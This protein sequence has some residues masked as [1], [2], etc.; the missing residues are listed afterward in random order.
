MAKHWYVTTTA[1]K[2][3]ALA[4]F[5]RI[6]FTR[7]QMKER[8]KLSKGAQLRSQQTWGQA[9]APN[10]DVAAVLERGGIREAISDS[11]HGPG[12]ALGS[13]I[14]MRC[15]QDSEGQVLELWLANTNTF[16]GMSQNNDVLKAYARLIS[17]DLAS[18]GHTTL[19]AK[20]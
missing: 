16:L 8:F 15:S 20:N 9:S 1:S 14:A 10:A 17:D 12:S 4:A 11:R 18:R 13:I 3:E 7:P 2:E 6:F 5:A 19:L